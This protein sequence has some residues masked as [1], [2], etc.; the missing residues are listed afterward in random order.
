MS[1]TSTRYYKVTIM[2][3]DNLEIR[4][5]KAILRMADDVRD[6][7]HKLSHFLEN[8]REDYYKAIDK[9]GQ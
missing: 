9:A 8:Y 2:S 3:S 4:S 7:N 5:K 1:T 6:M